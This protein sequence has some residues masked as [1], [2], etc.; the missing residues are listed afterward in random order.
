M[1]CDEADVPSHYSLT[2]LLLGVSRSISL[3]VDPEAL[4]AR[5]KRAPGQE[6]AALDPIDIET[7]RR[8]WHVI[9]Q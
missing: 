5:Q 3:H 4:R 1:T 2:R 6:A 8:L 7:R 9:L